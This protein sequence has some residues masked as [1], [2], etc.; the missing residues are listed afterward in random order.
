MSFLSSLGVESLGED[1][2]GSGGKLPIGTHVADVVKVNVNEEKEQIGVQVKY[3]D[4]GVTR[5]F[6][7]N[8]KA[9]TPEKT[10]IAKRMSVKQLRNAGNVIKTDADIPKAVENL[11]GAGL[12]ISISNNKNNPA[13]QNFFIDGNVPRKRGEDAAAAAAVD[14]ND[15]IPF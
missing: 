3:R 4:L 15:E 9:S 8:F 2:Q 11:E 5:W 13:Y 12:K 6:N 7:L 10:V 14:D 1:E